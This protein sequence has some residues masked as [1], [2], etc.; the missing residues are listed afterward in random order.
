MA[1]DVLDAPDHAGEASQ[2]RETATRSRQRVQPPVVN[3]PEDKQPAEGENPFSQFDGDPKDDGIAVMERLRLNRQDSYYRGSLAGSSRLTALSHLAATPDGPDVD[4]ARKKVNDEQRDEYHKITADLAAH[5]LLNPWDTTLEA[6]AAFGGQLEGTMIS[7]ESW[8]GWGAKGAGWAIRTAKA[9]LQQAFIQGATDP[10]VQALNTA[11]GVQQ[12]GWDWRRTVISAGMGFLIGGAGHAAGE[13]LEKVVGPRMAR[14]QFLDLAREDKSFENHMINETTL[15][16]LDPS[17]GRALGLRENVPI[18][19][20]RPQA[21]SDNVSVKH[22]GGADEKVSGVRGPNGEQQPE[23]LP[24]VSREVSGGPNAGNAQEGVRGHGAGPV[25]GFEDTVAAERERLSQS[26]GAAQP[27]AGQLN[28]DARFSAFQKEVGPQADDL[29]SHYG[30]D[31]KEAHALY[32]HYDR[33]P[34]EHPDEALR[35]AAVSWYDAEERAALSDKN[36][37]GAWRSE[38]NELDRHFAS[39]EGESTGTADGGFR[40][41]D[42]PGEF[43]PAQRTNDGTAPRGDNLYGRPGSDIPFESGVPAREGGAV[44][45]GGAPVAREPGQTDARGATGADGGTGSRAA[46][47]GRGERVED[48]G[49]QALAS[50][51]GAGKLNNEQSRAAAGTPV[52]LSPIQDLT[53]RSLQQQVADLA[54]AL[55]IPLREGRVTIQGAG[56][57]YRS[58]YG[59]VRVKEYPDFEIAVHEA[60]HAIEAKIGPDMTALTQQHHFDLAPLDYDQGPTGKRI[61]EGFAEWVRLYV[62]NPSFAQQVAPNFA[63]DFR[64]FMRAEHPAILSELDKASAGYRAYL[65]APSVDAVGSVRRSAADE[66]HGLIQETRAEIKDKGLPY[67]IKSVLQEG[68]RR[69]LDDKA[70]VTRVVRELGLAIRE[71][72]GTAVELKAADNPDTL[73]RLAGRSQQ[74]SVRDMMDGVRP[75]HSITPEGPSLADALAEATGKPSVWGAWD[76]PKKA[77]FSHYVIARRAEFLWRKFEQGTLPNPPAAFSRADA[78]Q[79]MAD[80]EKANPTFRNASDMVHQYGLNLLKKRFEGHLITRDLYDKLAAEEFYAPFM[81][82]MRDKPGAT[83]GAGGAEGPGTVSTVMGMKGSSRDILDPIESLMMQTFLVNRTIRQND[84]HLALARYAERAGDRG[85]KYV[86]PIPAFELRKHGEIP[87]SEILEQ[88]ARDIGMTPDDAADWAATIGHTLGEDPI[89]GS[90]W[91]MEQTGAKGEPIAFYKEGGELRAHRLMSKE[92]GHALYETMTAAPDPI[93]DVWVQLA[94]TSATLL[95]STITTNPTFMVAN[96]IR[97]QFAASILRSDYVPIVGG[98][99]GL[100]DEFRQGQNAVLYGYA[101]GVAG[102]AATGPV[103]RAVEADVNAL[104]KKGYVV[105]R[106]TSFKG[107]LE[108][109]SATEAGTR[110]SIFA[111]VFDAKKRAGLSDYEAMVEAAFQ[112]QDMLDF[113]RHGSMTMVIRKLLPFVNAHMQGLDKASRTMIEPIINRMKTGDVFTRDSADFKNAIAAWT[114]AGAIGGGLGALTAALFWEKEGYRDANPYLKGTHLVVPMGDRLLVVPKPFELSTGFTLGEY[115]FARLMKD[116]PRAGR[117][118]IEAAWQSMQPPNPLTDLPLVGGATSLYYGKNLQTGND[119]VPGTLQRLPPAQQ[120]T[121]RT[122]EMAK[123]LG[124]QIDV[125]PMKIDYAIGANFGNWGRDVMALSQGLNEDSPAKNF[126]NSVFLRRFIKDP[127]TS[128]DITTKFW[129]FMGQTTGKYNQA[130]A[131]YDALVKGFQDDTGRAQEFLSKLPEAEKAFVTLKSAGTPEGKPAFNADEKR[132]HPLQRSYDAVTVLGQL[133]R[134]LTDNTF[135]DFASLQRLKLDPEKRRDLINDLRELSQMEMRNA[136]V[137]TKEPGYEGRSIFDTNDVMDRIRNK[138]PEIANEIATRYAVA[139][140]YKT[141]T[142][143]NAWPQLR[144]QLVQNGSKAD[145]RMLAYDAKAQG[146]AFDGTRVKRPQKRRVAVEGSPAPQP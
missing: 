122:S 40:S 10:A 106:F 102:G 32:E 28:D 24:G 133:R 81:R 57:V 132:L 110:N 84:V 88:K 117:Q 85:G 82:D 146:Y 119:I 41:G 5:D 29:L 51:R 43:G 34:G 46:E 97:D 86:E 108:V 114:K 124:K 23:L 142:V 56:G 101:G 20:E 141:E 105:Q 11:A 37:D 76:G 115:A 60:G 107:L 9:G 33:A 27:K 143:Q 100:L 18:N 96:Y 99:R 77:E 83:G 98:V 75:Y 72:T 74:A 21:L 62:G 134:E 126:D 17:N 78:L 69:T 35:R 118:F 38:M 131:G 53:V 138:S 127:T 13:G 89:L 116:D 15:A 92:E 90:Y 16:S 2:A 49:D 7:P 125:S 65:E 59:T 3:A 48:R 54:K 64:A 50:R 95:R 121:D 70:P 79:A 112:A 87:V 36:L 47:A 104:A 128:S 139:K 123:W 130:V 6:A 45:E 144:D 91:K 52:P 12:G 68:Y 30:F 109:A 93:T 31:P 22:S 44:A 129:D 94:A 26:Y 39:R 14:K 71:K 120:Y 4:P 63:Q 103:E 137:I 135:K 8:I 66:P 136:L 1:D 58:K 111:T 145:V 80:L 42:R 61:N 67:V 73:L 19:S 113:S 55:D 25:H 140:I